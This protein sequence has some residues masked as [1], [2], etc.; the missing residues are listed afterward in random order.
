MKMIAGLRF[1][2]VLLLL[3]FIASANTR[4]GATWRLHL[5]EG[6]T[7]DQ[8][9]VTQVQISRIFQQQPEQL[10]LITRTRLHNEVLRANAD[11]SVMIKSTFQSV[12]TERYTLKN[13]TKLP[14]QQSST[15]A[16][17]SAAAMQGKS[18]QV[19]FSPRGEMLKYEGIDAI[20]R[21]MLTDIK[22]PDMQKFM[23]QMTT[24]SL[25]GIARQIAGE[26]TFPESAV[27]V[28]DSWKPPTS[29]D[30]NPNIATN[31]T[32]MS[33]QDGV[34]VVALRSDAASSKTVTEQPHQ[35][36]TRTLAGTSSGVIRIDE[37]TGLIRSYE[38]HGE[39]HTEAK[40][41]F[42]AQHYQTTSRGWTL[43]PASAK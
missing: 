9:L 27:T 15:A 17:Q 24:R 30:N 38:M 39:S 31:Y 16:S 32:L 4:D 26:V 12:N 42:A 33:Q 29:S 5:Q 25:E 21:A 22:N 36:T 1:F 14:L 7:F 28:G 2:V 6:Q 10:I 35:H 43:L 11:G 13:G 41:T 20:A 19:T 37:K 3:C 40:G 8:G 18:F 34:A 23:L